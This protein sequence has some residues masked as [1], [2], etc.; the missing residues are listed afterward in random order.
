MRESM[1]ERV[2]KAIVAAHD[3]W[4]NGLKHPMVQNPLYRARMAR[5]AI[6]ALRE[7][8]DE[9]HDAGNAADSSA[10]MGSYAIWPAMIDAALKGEG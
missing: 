8:T 10:E 7:P 2:A 6:L 3:E 9:M 1:I 4:M 5:A